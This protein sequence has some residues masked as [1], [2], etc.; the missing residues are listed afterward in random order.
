[1]LD[2]GLETGNIAVFMVSVFLEQNG[3]NKCIS[4]IVNPKETSKIL[5]ALFLFYRLHSLAF[6]M[7][8]IFLFYF[9]Q[10][11]NNLSLKRAAR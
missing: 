6:H 11:R 3:E 5:I 7:Q 10:I 8:I 1:M 9:P 4:V 2:D